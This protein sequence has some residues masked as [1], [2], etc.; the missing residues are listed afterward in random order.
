MISILIIGNEIL[1]AQVVDFN[2]KYMLPRLAKAGYQVDEVRI[3][4]DTLPI[5]TQSILDLSQR[6]QFLISTGGIGP[7]HDDLTMK[8]YADAFQCGLMQHPTLEARIRAHYGEKLRPEHLQHA[9][10]PENAELV[11]SD[12]PSWPLV[13]VANCFVLPGLPEAF[14]K[15]FP[16]ILKALPAIPTWHFAA[17]MATCGEAQFAESLTGIQREFTD[18]EI[19]SYPN[20]HREDYRAKISLKGRNLSDLTAAFHRI[21][22]L[23]LNQES[24]ASVVEPQPYDPEIHGDIFQHQPESD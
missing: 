22:A 16:G 4:P 21:Q 15:K 7:T 1:S 13:K 23:I 12:N 3:I 18:V 24:L 19:G 8:A 2:L 5:I 20:W 11:P 14:L 10:V 6:S 17:V 9:L